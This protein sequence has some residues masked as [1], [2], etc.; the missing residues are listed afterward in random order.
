MLTKNED[1]CMGKKGIKNMIVFGVKCSCY[2]FKRE[3]PV[4]DIGDD[5]VKPKIISQAIKPDQ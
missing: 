2:L 5:L 4:I 1:R 3:I